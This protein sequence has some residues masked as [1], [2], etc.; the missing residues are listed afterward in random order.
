M[1]T[2]NGTVAASSDDARQVS[3]GT[4]ELT[5]GYPNT[6][7]SAVW[8]GFRFTNVTIPQGSTINSASIILAILANDDPD[9]DIYGNDV[10]DAATFTSTAYNISDRALTTAKVN[11]TAS[12]IGAYATKSSPDIA[13]IIQEIV[14]RAGWASGNDIVILFDSLSSS[15]INFKAYDSGEGSSAYPKITIDYT[16]PAGG[17]NPKTGRIRL[18]TRVGGVLIQ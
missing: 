9:L 16:E 14:D 15:Y 8:V 10:D 18:T 12:N 5:G 17:A 4:M 6:N 1:A 2:F 13:S 3:G 11:W 7:G